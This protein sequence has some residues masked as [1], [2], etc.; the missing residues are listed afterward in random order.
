MPCLLA[1]GIK[2][3][4]SIDLAILCTVAS[5]NPPLSLS[6]LISLALFNQSPIS[7]GQNSEE[8]VELSGVL[9]SGDVPLYKSSSQAL[10]SWLQS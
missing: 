7:I 9:V 10:L 8:L 2:N 4:L 5:V 6:V 3:C 1:A